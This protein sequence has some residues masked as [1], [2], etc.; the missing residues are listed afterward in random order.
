MEL[1]SV[2]QSL[3]L[4]LSQNVKAKMETKDTLNIKVMALIMSEDNRCVGNLM[5]TADDVRYFESIN[6]MR[7]FDSDTG[8]VTVDRIKA[9]RVRVADMV[10]YPAKYNWDI[11]RYIR[12]IT[13]LVEFL[14][15]FEESGTVLRIL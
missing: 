2:P 7:A 5:L 8:M 9:I 15:A 4:G 3:Q 10:M 13:L 11:K 14:L 6:L 12:T 1:C